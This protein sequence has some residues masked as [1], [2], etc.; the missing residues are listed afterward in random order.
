MMSKNPGFTVVVVFI[1]SLGI[2]A[3]IAIFNA[4]DQVSLRRLPVKKARELVGIHFLWHNKEGQSITDGIFHYPLYE[5][6]RD[7]SDVFS[8]LTAFSYDD[9]C[10]RINQEVTKLQGLAVSGNYFSV[11]GVTSYIGRAF[12]P[13]QEPDTAIHPVVIISDRFRRQR[14]GTDTDIIGKQIMINDH[15]LTIVGVTPPGFTGSVVGWLTD[16]YIPL[17]TYVG[18][19]NDNIHRD[20]WTWLHFLGRLKPGISREQAQTSL[21]IL[22]KHLK[23]SGLNNVHDNVLISDGSR[24]WISWDAKDFHR[25]LVL[26]MIVAVSVL[27]IAS[28]N[29]ANMQLSRAMTRQKEIAIR[30]A[31]G[32]GRWRV[33]RQLLVESLLL[34][35]GGCICGIVLA[36]WLNRVMCMLMSRIGS[37]NIIPGLD[38]RILLFALVIS[39]L[40][41]LVFGLSPALQVVRRNVTP[42]L[43]KSSGFIDLPIGSWNPHQ[44]L[45]T[46]QVAV[47]VVVLVCA[48]LFIYNII[49][50]TRIDPGYD[51]RKLLAVSLEGRTFDQP[52]V[53]RFFE[54]LHDRIKG[55]PGTEASCLADSVPL[56][57]RGSRRGV[58]H[59]DGISQ[60]FS[61][62]YGVVSP[63]YFKMLNMPLLAG[64]IFSSKDNLHAPRVMVIND[65]MARQ[66]WPNQD[67]LGKYVTF[68]GLKD[69][70]TVRVIGVV[71][72]SKMRSLIEGQRPIA[73]WPLAQDTR[74][75]CV[76]LIRTTGNPKVLIP[77][78]RREAA[79]VGLNE[80]CHIR[81]VADR[82]GDLLYPQHATTTILN[83]FGLAALLL[84]V[85]GIFS[86]MAFTVKQR[87]REIGIRM[88]LGAES[89]HI[90]TSILRRGAWL[91]VIG[92]GL[93]LG[94]S[95][96]AIR[97]LE[98]QLPGLQ[99]WDKFLLFGVHIWDP[100]TLVEMPLLVLSV[101]LLA[102]YIP[103]RHA[104]KIDPME[105]L[106]YE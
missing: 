61:C 87:T 93:G 101:A 74:F 2:G 6:Y 89:H 102:C 90:V 38:C 44:L 91:A 104:A 41:G 45:V 81:T 40:T 71:K 72:G 24:G 18:M 92:L 25:P 5:A 47:A 49:V 50:L 3:N 105:A 21:G 39:L 68:G 88:A 15:S 100:V 66:C 64:R 43:R 53:R 9:V 78:I 75:T 37:I 1:I 32:A 106:R 22:S 97:I 65:I 103:A 59:V 23:T 63:D 30:Q 11:L 84:C 62:Q 34:A 99:K 33:I 35:L 60:Q 73:Y 98:G 31:L 12:S 70:L 27:V 13:E 20:S 69:G 57:E 54:E 36:L 67:P 77:I 82:V 42:A 7:Q 46:F 80:V 94:L 85:T 96:I 79:D 17:G 4:L 48:G 19:R 51:T 16:I 95:L 86:V 52:K 14:F 28:F 29:V 83:V 10:F 55:L 8:G 76:L 56:C 26:F 58:S